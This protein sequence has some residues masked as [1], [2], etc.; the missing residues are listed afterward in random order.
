MS[1]DLDHLLGRLSAA[2]VSIPPGFART[3]LAG[4][5]TQREESRRSRTLAPVRL[6]SVSFAV[7]IGLTAGGMA[8]VTAA[9]EPRQFSTFSAAPH[10]APSTLLEGRG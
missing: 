9:A 3:V 10:L 6:A 4:I 2:E 7:A 1:D 8:A 5:A